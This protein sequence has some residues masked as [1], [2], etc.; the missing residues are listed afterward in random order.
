MATVRKTPSGR[1]QVIV[2]KKGLPQQSKTFAKK[3]DADRYG[4]KIESDMDQ[5]VFVDLSIAHNW[6]VSKLLK[7]YLN[8]VVIH[9]PI[10]RVDQY[11]VKPLVA[12]MGQ[13]SLAMLTPSIV[14]KYR[15]KRLETLTGSSVKRE[16]GY[17]QRAINYAIKDLGIPFPKGNPVSLIRL[18]KENPPRERIPTV[19]EINC[20]LSNASQD[21]KPLFQ[22]AIE[23]CMRRSEI[24]RIAWNDVDLEARVL[25]IP[26]TK[27]GKPRSIP[28]S[29]TALEML[30]QRK[31]ELQGPFVFR[32]DSI[33]QA[34]SRACERSN[35]KG[36]VFHSLRHYGITRLFN[37]GLSIMEVSSISGHLDVRMLRRYT[38]IKPED[39]LHKL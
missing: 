19:E 30:K 18:P 26:K 8:E 28:L 29:L 15:D 11:L 34:F 38:H 36:V 20:I 35:I 10:Y 6:T 22:F 14:S 12:Q 24:A 3:A 31:H 17:L 33:T 21:M 2:R 9:K 16:L 13:Y 39:I 32:P 4:K 1:W 37:K 25:R 23:T 5:G 7:Q 27:N